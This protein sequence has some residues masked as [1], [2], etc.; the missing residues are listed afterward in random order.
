M[1]NFLNYPET[2]PK[3]WQGDINVIAILNTFTL[4]LIEEIN[5]LRG[6][7]PDKPNH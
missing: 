3:Y 4:E 1:N 5:E 6:A 2:T 7:S